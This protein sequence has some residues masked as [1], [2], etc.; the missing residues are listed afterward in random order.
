MAILML[1]RFFLSQR[2]LWLLASG[3]ACG[4]GALFHPFALVFGIQLSAGL[5]IA[6]SGIKEKLK[7]MLIL[8]IGCTMAVS[9]WVPLIVLFPDEFKSQF[10]SNVL[11][12][13]GPGLL[14]RIVYPWL[15]LSHHMSLLFAYLGPWQ[16]GLHVA[17]LILGTLA[18][19]RSFPSR[20]AVGYVLLCWSS[21]CL[22]AVVA[23]FHPTQGYWV[24][25]SLWIMAGFAPFLQ[26]LIPAK[27]SVKPARGF[28]TSFRGLRA[29][30]SVI[31]I[32]FLVSLP[33]A[34]LKTTYIYYAN[35]GAPKFHGGNFIGKVLSDMP[36]DGLFLVDLS[37][38]FDV[39]LSGRKT[40]SAQDRI[41]YWPDQEIDYTAMLLAWQGEDAGIAAQYNGVHEKRVGS[42]EIDQECF[43]DIYRRSDEKLFLDK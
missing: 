6:N 2:L 15:S 43:V 37:Y 25:A 42:R 8:V 20:F 31:L 21:V 13:A 1:Y 34:G 38:V 7:Q 19:V 5:V 40:I 36:Q 23:G 27:D 18:I 32:A 29:G 39:Y 28:I 41:I 4:L 24:Y 3:I 11:E 33:G 30:W 26:W 22:T 17:A 35:W 10:F 14:S 9:M 16:L 12:R